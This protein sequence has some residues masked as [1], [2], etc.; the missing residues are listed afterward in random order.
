MTI[1]KSLSSIKLLSELKMDYHI[2]ISTINT[3]HFHVVLRNELHYLSVYIYI[4]ETLN[5]PTCEHGGEIYTFLSV[6]YISTTV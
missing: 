3:G 2:Y 4:S 1:W 6:L 5:L